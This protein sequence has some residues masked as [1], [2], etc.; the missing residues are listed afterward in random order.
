[1]RSPSPSGTPSGSWP[2][3]PRSSTPEAT[4][5]SDIASLGDGYKMG[6]DR[7]RSLNII[8]RHDVLISLKTQFNYEEKKNIL[9]I[10]F[11]DMIKGESKASIFVLEKK[12]KYSTFGKAIL[13]IVI[14]ARF[15]KKIKYL[16]LLQNVR[17]WTFKYN[18]SSKLLLLCLSSSSCPELFHV[19]VCFS[20]EGMDHEGF[21]TRAV[22]QV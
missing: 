12:M 9:K 22:Y 20:I 7:V 4:I 1:M 21:S 3:Q 13:V 15:R 18:F 16:R 8:Q 14:I 5:S 17:N 2:S 19:A 6:Y 11:S 10:F